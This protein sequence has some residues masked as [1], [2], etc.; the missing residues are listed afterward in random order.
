MKFSM[1][2]LSHDKDTGEYRLKCF[3]EEKGRYGEFYLHL[4]MKEM[5]CEII[6]KDEDYLTDLMA[7]FEEELS[8]ENYQEEAEKVVLDE[9]EPAELI[10]DGNN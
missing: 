3:Y 8:F 4:N 5:E 9:K 2:G 6:A 10:N 1:L 7:G